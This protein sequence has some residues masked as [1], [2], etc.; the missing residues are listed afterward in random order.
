MKNKLKLCDI[1][2]LCSSISVYWLKKRKE[3]HKKK[4]KHFFRIICLQRLQFSNSYIFLS[5]C[6]KLILEDEK[7]RNQI[8]SNNT[9]DSDVFAK[10]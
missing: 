8:Q 4:Q 9:F 7:K 5:T 2:D 6:F 1:V 10:R 3:N